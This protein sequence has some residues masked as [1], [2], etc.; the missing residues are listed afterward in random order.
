MFLALLSLNVI[1]CGT[2]EFDIEWYEIALWIWIF[3]SL[4]EEFVQYTEDSGIN[5]YYY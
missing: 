4:V 3:A 2:D 1:E 5:Y